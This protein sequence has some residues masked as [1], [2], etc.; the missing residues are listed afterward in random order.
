MNI[1][2]S[3]F[4]CDPFK[5]SEASNGF[6]WATGL[7]AMGYEVTCLTRSVH[8]ASIEKV[9][10]PANLKFVYVDLSRFEKLYSAS[11]ASM[12]LYYI[13]WQKKA[14]RIAA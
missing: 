10:T 7:A 14:Q 4:A 5:G 1:L 2:L 6:N 3:A 9:A 8:K 13:L 11:Q 12:Y